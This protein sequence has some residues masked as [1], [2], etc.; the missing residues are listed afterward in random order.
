MHPSKIKCRNYPDCSRGSKCLYV[1]SDPM[2]LEEDNLNTDSTANAEMYRCKFCDN[3]FNT[4]RELNRHTTDDHK[5]YKPCKNF[6]ND[7]CDFDDDCRFNHIKLNGSQSICYKCGNITSSKTLL[8][9]HIKE[10]HG[11]TNSSK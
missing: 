6:H 4:R 8:M 3:S 7:S 2:D 9:N 10:A 11:Q 5:S 1:H